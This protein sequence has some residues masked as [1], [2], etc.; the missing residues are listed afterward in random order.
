ML[1]MLNSTTFA[2]VDD[3]SPEEEIILG[4]GYKQ[5]EDEAAMCFVFCILWSV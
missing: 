3:I 2:L 1:C 4:D 5:E